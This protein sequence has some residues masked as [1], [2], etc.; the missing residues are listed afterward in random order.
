MPL[1][2]ADNGFRRGLASGAE[3]VIMYAG[4]HSIAHPLDTLVEGIRRTSDCLRLRY[5]F[6]GGGLAKTPIDQWIA[7]DQPAAVRSL[8]YQPRER[9]REVLSAADVHVIVVGPKTVGVVHPSKTYG[10]LAA[11]RPVLVIGPKDSPAAR[12]VTEHNVGWW[13]EHGH[14]DELQSVLRH[15][16]Q[17]PDGE[18]VGVGQRAHQLAVSA[19]GRRALVGE[20]CDWL[21][22]TP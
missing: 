6:V 19:Y 14:V 10:A 2:H 5:V 12:I 11:G 18:L 7:R 21:E 4:N 20:L 8:P 22:S 16:A 13:V 1:A 17:M 3:R 9:I 15:I